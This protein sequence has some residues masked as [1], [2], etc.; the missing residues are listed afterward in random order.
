MDVR[1]CRDKNNSIGSDHSCLH[2]LGKQVCH[3]ETYRISICPVEARAGGDSHVL[4][5][6][7][8]SIK[9]NGCRRDG[10]KIP[11][12]LRAENSAHRGARQVRRNMTKKKSPGDFKKGNAS[13][14]HEDQN[15]RTE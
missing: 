1:D 13:N 14:T 9:G 10:D 8:R 3:N 5:Q 7:L 11:A 2:V 6:W 15:E 12:A 4:T